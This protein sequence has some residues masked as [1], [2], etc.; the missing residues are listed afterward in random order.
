MNYDAKNILQLEPPTTITIKQFINQ[1]LIHFSNYDNIRSIPSIIDGFKPSQRKVI[2]ACFKRN[3]INE[4]KIA[5]LAGAVAEITAYHHGEQSLVSTIINLAQNFVGSN[6][7]NLL[8]PIG[9]L[10]TRLIG[11]KDHSSARYIFTKLTE[12][13]FKIIKKEDNTILEHLDDDGIPIEP[14]FYLPIVPIC[15]INGAE[16]IG[17][18][19]R[20]QY[21]II[22]LKIF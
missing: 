6:N 2:Y 21:Q 9:Q 19:F 22:I 1:E 4:M 7:I 15:L 3:L 10:G 18:G 13:I 11:G 5:Q 17:T 16:G 14:K 20:L 8:E 12:F